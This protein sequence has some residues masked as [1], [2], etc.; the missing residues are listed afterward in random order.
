MRASSQEALPANPAL[1]QAKH[2]ST[3]EVDQVPGVI[4]TQQLALSRLTVSPNGVLF[5]HLQKQHDDFAA[6]TDKASADLYFHYYGMLMHQQNMLQDQVRTGTYYAAI[7]ENT[8]DFHN[9][10][11]MDVGAGSGVLSLF[12]AQAS[13][14]CK[15]ATTSCTPPFCSNSSNQHTHIAD[16]C[17]CLCRQEP[18]RCMLLRLLEWLSMPNSLLQ[19]QVRLLVA[20]WCILLDSCVSFHGFPEHVACCGEG[21]HLSQPVSNSTYDTCN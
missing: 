9:K 1:Q 16:Q 3:S 18:A 5:A 20:T 14:N 7:V 21:C 2:A 17:Q 19:L 8:A 13:L 4:A 10:V 12:A 6:K 11:V 15:S